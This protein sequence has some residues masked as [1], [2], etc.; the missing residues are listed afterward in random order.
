MVNGAYAH[1]LL[2]GKGFAAEDIPV[3]IEFIKISR[4]INYAKKDNWVDGAGYWG[5][6]E[7]IH[8]ERKRREELRRA[9]GKEN[10]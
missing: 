1:L 4:E 5:V 10:D 8:Q 9:Q 2:P 3:I 6:I 7:M